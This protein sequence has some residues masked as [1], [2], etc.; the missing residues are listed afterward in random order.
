MQPGEATAERLCERWLTCRGGVLIVVCVAS[1]LPLSLGLVLWLWFGLFSRPGS[2]PVLVRSPAQ[3]GRD[4][5]ALAAA[6]AEL[7][8]AARR[9]P[10]C[11]EEGRSLPRCFAEHCC[12]SWA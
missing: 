3:Q 8:L 4:G 2:D 12:L 7:Q 1:G 5:R 11:G 9:R 10:E 6:R